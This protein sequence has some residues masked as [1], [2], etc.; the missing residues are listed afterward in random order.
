MLQVGNTKLHDRF[1]KKAQPTEE[2]SGTEEGGVADVKGYTAEAALLEK[3][4]IFLNPIK[5]Y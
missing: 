2:R 1:N 3:S 4:L 5:L